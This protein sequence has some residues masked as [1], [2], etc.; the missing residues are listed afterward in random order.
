MPRRAAAKAAKKRERYTPGHARF[1]ERNDFQMVPSRFPP[2]YA[3]KSRVCGEYIEEGDAFDVVSYK[4]QGGRQGR[5]TNADGFVSHVVFNEG[6][7]G[8]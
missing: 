3:P 6:G 8:V 2:G 4:T 7:G 5:P 1:L